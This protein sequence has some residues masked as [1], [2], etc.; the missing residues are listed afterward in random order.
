MVNVYTGNSRRQ[1]PT[2][3]VVEDEPFLRALLI[4]VLSDFNASVHVEE[5]ADEGFKALQRLQ[6][7]DLI[8]TDVVTPGGL[9][10]I[11]LALAAHE[12]RPHL[13]IIVTSGSSPE[14]RIRLPPSARFLPK[15]WTLEVFCRTVESVLKTRA[16]AMA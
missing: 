6:H 13:P 12:L 9:N 4:D 15:P 14:A 3:L 8:I 11:E 2:I 1:M 16:G 7:L 5:T 10:G